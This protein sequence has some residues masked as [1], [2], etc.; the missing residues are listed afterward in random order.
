MNLTKLYMKESS[1]D[2]DKY[3][4]IVL[5]I[6]R[7][8]IETF[9]HITILRSLD[10]IKKNARKYEGKLNLM[11]TGFDDDQRELH[12]IEEVKRYF[13][14][15]DRCFPYWFYF[16]I[17]TIPSRYSPF[18]ILLSL[19]VPIENIISKNSVQFNIVA[20]EQFLNVHFHFLNELTD[21]LGLPVS[22]N[23]RISEEVMR[24]FSIL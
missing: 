7:K 2:P 3:G 22:E 15:L 4:M 24:N 18:T 21:E 16:L 11:V 9:N 12:E 10:N 13:D 1:P 19:L 6:S 14:F 8:E 20:F 23:M 17:K 5:T